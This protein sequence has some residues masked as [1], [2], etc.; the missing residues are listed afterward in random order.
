[1]LRF[2]ATR[3]GSA[4]VLMLVLSAAVFVLARVIPG[5]PA[6]VYLGPRARPDEL[7]RIREQ[8][9]LDDPLPLQFVH[10]LTGLVQG[11]WG[12]SL[13]T[14]RPVLL[15]FAERLPATLEL[16][17]VA[18]VIATVGGIV[19]GVIASGRPGG[20]VDGLVRV[21]T[22]GGVSMPAFW[23]GLLLQVFFV[24]QLGLLPATGQTS[25]TLRFTSPIEHV[26]GFQLVDS[27]I[28]GNL[29]ALADVGAHLVLPAITLAAY[30][31][32]LIARMTRSSMLDVGELDYIR[33]ANAYGLRQR[34]I[35][36][37]LALRNAISPTI[38]VIGLSAA[39]TLTATFYVEIV[40]N[41]PGIGPFATNALLAVDSPVI[42]VLALLSAAA[43]LAAN[44]VVD[45]L[46]A[47]VD[48]RV[49]LR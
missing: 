3:V 33:T 7:A 21:L 11:D 5:D 18:L 23:L 36:W 25:S 35:R 1:M 30:P 15:E 12:T 4:L 19:L 10:F 20:V 26:T 27:L 17:T 8:L 44:V 16:L 14:K 24:G 48:P 2:L 43:Y 49:R 34:T 46:Q 41:W 38:T 29:T 40:F 9:G 37:R 32:G 42:I 13:V 22:I 28:T 45:L 31:L 6:V 39:Y 47:A